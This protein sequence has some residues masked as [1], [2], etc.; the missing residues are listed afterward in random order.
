MLPLASAGEGVCGFYRAGA[1]IA[2]SYIVAVV[3]LW[4]GDYT[5]K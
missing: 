2:V 3:A 1:M 5:F 4:A